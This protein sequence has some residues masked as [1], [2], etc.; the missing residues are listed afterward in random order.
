MRARDKVIFD[1]GGVRRFR[2]LLS[3][4]SRESLRTISNL[5]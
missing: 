3:S 1:C 4:E 2:E 5:I